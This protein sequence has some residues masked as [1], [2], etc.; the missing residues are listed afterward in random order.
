MSESYA[1]RADTVKRTTQESLKL[2][3][4]GEEVQPKSVNMDT[5]EV[6]IESPKPKG[7]I[8][9][10]MYEPTDEPTLNPAYFHSE[11]IQTHLMRMEYT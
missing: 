11:C 8:I 2:Y 9:A 1:K 4:D 10:T 6:E 7:T 3:I 5:G